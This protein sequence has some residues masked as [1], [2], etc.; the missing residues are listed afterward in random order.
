MIKI[1]LL[2][3]H[4]IAKKE[5]YLRQI[6]LFT[7]GTALFVLC[8]IALYLWSVGSVKSLAEEVKSKEDRLSALNKMVGEVDRI[9]LEKKALEK[10]LAVI[11]ELERGRVYTVKLLAD[12]ASQVPV[13][14]V[15]LEKLVQSESNIQ[16]EGK[17]RDNFAIVQLMKNLEASPFILSV[18]LVSSK[19]VEEA[20][21]KLQQFQLSCAL[22]RGI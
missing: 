6:T 13:G 14:S 1:N 8:L 15:W 10:K 12:I 19:Q 5:T 18:E 22:K 3:Y 11:G 7:T 2:P 17:A 9:K 21:V 16:L 20:Q 4:E